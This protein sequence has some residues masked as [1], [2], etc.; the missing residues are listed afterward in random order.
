[1]RIRRAIIKWLKPAL[2]AELTAESDDLVRQLAVLNEA[3]QK[4][5]ELRINRKDSHRQA[6][7]LLALSNR[8]GFLRPLLQVLQHFFLE[9]ISV[10]AGENGSQPLEKR[11]ER[12]L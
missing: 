2:I 7:R 6:D 8:S 12:P 3:Y 4:A 10:D 9:L 1:M 11:P 5:F